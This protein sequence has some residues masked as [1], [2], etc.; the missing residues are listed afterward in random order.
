MYQK[1]E[2][3]YLDSSQYYTENSI[4]PYT[5]IRIV[6]V[7]ENKNELYELTHKSIGTALTKEDYSIDIDRG[8]VIFAPQNIGNLFKIEYYTNGDVNPF[9]ISENL[10]F[11]VEEFLRWSKMRIISGLYFYRNNDDR[12]SILRL[13]QGDFV[14]RGD[15]YVCKEKVYDFSY[16]A[17]PTISGK[18]RGYMFYINAD[19]I[20]EH[21][22]LYRPLMTIDEPSLLIT[23]QLYEHTFQAK[24]ELLG[25]YKAAYPNTEKIILAFVYLRIDDHYN[26]WVEYPSGFRMMS[27]KFV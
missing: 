11:I 7:D 22:N 4:V 5:E 17:A 27:R 10:F 21:T 9:S 19:T 13:H 8:L 18:F 12:E 16:L 25:R 1:T 6:R 26:F 15:Y 3:F 20:D 14:Y 23:T 2:Y 24:N